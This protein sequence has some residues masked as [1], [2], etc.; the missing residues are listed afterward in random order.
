MPR[1][2]ARIAAASA[3]VPA[4]PEARAVAEAL[5][6]TP[7]DCAPPRFSGLGHGL[8]LL[9]D[10]FAERRKDRRRVSAHPACVCADALCYRMR[11]VRCSHAHSA[12][13]VKRETGGGLPPCL[14]CPRNGTPPARR[15]S[16]RTR[17]CRPRCHC[18][19]PGGKA[20]AWQAA[21]PDTG[22][23]KGRARCS[24]NARSAGDGPGA[25]SARVRAGF[26]RS[27]MRCLSAG[28]RCAAR[29]PLSTVSTRCAPCRAR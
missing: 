24:P 6:E 8:H 16:P 25:H 28:R 23:R 29:L 14:C 9:G 3:A 13:A 18:P 1:S 20:A 7:D 10:M 17:P 22:R 27:V 4:R 19:V 2:V 15:A 5:P 26:A 21:S 11:R 12:H